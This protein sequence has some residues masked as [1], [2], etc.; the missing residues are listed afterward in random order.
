[1]RLLVV[2]AF[3][4]GILT[5]AL[6]GLL[7]MV[8]ELFCESIREAPSMTD[9]EAMTENSSPSSSRERVRGSA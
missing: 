6:F 4:I 2:G 9:K 7:A 1:M 8:R 5:L 3:A